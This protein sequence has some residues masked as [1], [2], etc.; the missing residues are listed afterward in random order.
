V[1]S[2][3]LAILLKFQEKELGKKERRTKGCP[4]KHH[5]ELS[6]KFNPTTQAF[7]SPTRA[8]C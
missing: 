4:S 2:G 7:I 3:A 6:K 5:E 1:V 8:P